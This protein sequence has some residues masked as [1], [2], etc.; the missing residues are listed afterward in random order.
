MSAETLSSTST[1]RELITG[2]EARNKALEMIDAA[3]REPISEVEFIDEGYLGRLIDD[4]AGSV[5]IRLEEPIDV[6]LDFIKG[7]VGFVSWEEGRGN[8][9]FESDRGGS[10]QMMKDYASRST[11]MPANESGLMVYLM[12]DERIFGVAQNSHRTG[13]AKMRGDATIAIKGDITVQKLT[14][15]PLEFRMDEILGPIN[16]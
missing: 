7:A 12:P 8:A 6:P 10:V 2:L 11:P 16:K 13:A 4:E 5:T 15:M 3:L 14:K 1:R 9:R